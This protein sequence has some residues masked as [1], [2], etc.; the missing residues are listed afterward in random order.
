[1]SLRRAKL[2]AKSS[3]A[4]TTS[5]IF[6]FSSAARASMIRVVDTNQTTEEFFYEEISTITFEVIAA[7]LI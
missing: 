6:E 5:A 2:F 4:S 3:T 1:M 7:R